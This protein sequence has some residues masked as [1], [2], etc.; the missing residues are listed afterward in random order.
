LFSQ[1]IGRVNHV[2]TMSKEWAD[3]L[4]EQMTMKQYYILTEGIEFTCTAVDIEDKILRF[5]NHKTTPFLPICKAV[6]MT[7]SFPFVFKALSWQPQWGKYYIHYINTRR[8]VDLTN[9]QFSDGGIL[10]N[11]PM[12]FLDNE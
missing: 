2:M 12:I 4:A 10:A 3:Y 5:L 9:H 6:Q 8:E 11:F 1:A 7:A